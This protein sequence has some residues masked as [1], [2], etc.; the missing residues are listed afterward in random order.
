MKASEILDKFKKVL[1]SED[2]EV[3]IAETPQEVELAEQAQPE[4]IAEEVV[5]AEEPKEEEI[6]EEV[7]EEKDSDDD[8]YATKEELAKA[9]AEM[10]A[11]YEGLMSS[12]DKKEE[13][14]VPQELSAQTEEVEVD[15]AA[16]EVAPITHTPEAE[17]SKAPLSLYA[18]K[19]PKTTVDS[20]FNKLFK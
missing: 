1:L 18:Q 16:E 17:V 11:M 12:M 6:V 9:L 2:G 15:L 10:K 5:L 8:K 19:G 13:M 7:I 14:E 4:A 3:T 20:V